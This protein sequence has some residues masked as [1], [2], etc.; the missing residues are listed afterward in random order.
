MIPIKRPWAK[1]RV[2]PSVTGGL[3]ILSLIATVV[4]W[5]LVLTPVAEPPI[6]IVPGSLPKKEEVKVEE[7][8]SPAPEIAEVAQNG[9]TYPNT[10]SISDATSLTVVVNKKYRLPSDYVPAVISVRGATLR[11]EAA[12]ALDSLLSGAE[13]DGHT[14]KVISSYRSYSTQVTVYRG[15]VAQY[16]EA[17]ADT[18]SARPGHSEHQ[19]G[20][21]VD[22]GNA[23]G[24]CDLEICF[25]ATAFGTWVKTNA[26]LYG[27]I[28][29]YPEG[30]E[31][32]TG[33]QYEPWHL[34]YI[35]IDMAETMYQTGQ[36]LDQYLGVPAGG[37]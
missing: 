4:V 5:R 19:T 3:F 6:S 34:R 18:F 24:S 14:P 10:L 27:F 21:A 26:H 2:H 20:L 36:T 23:N 32:L 8:K 22:V 16:G 15:F 28:V 1:K 33:Y 9:P 7:V 17:Q 11:A 37:Y 35:G 31:S 29:R 13:I 30:K 25:G 12:S